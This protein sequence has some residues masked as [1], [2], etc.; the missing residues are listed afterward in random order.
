[1]RDLAHY[2]PEFILF[3]E[4]AMPNE[5]SPAVKIEQNVEPDEKIA[6]EKRGYWGY[7]EMTKEELADSDCGGC[8]CGE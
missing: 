7:R 5:K 3:W 2:L 8:G 1:V 4:D 6:V